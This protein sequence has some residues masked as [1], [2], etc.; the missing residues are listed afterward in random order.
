[1]TDSAATPSPMPA[2]PMP[3]ARRHAPAI[4]YIDNA[5]E[6]VA[7]P[8][9]A[10]FRIGDFTWL[11]PADGSAKLFALFG[12]ASLALP[13]AKKWDSIGAGF[14]AALEAR[15]AKV[16]PT[17]WGDERVARPKPDPEAKKRAALD[18]LVDVIRVCKHT[19]GL[20]FDEP[21]VR[22]KLADAAFARKVRKEPHI[23][24][25]IARRSGAAAQPP[26]TL[27]GL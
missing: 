6:P 4:V 23:A 12:A 17:A 15:F 1:M 9:A 27:A 26:D 11:M 14:G 21:T 10:G 24:A 13:I 5:G 25:E 18:E 19:A 3:A 22:G 20:A 16:S 7:M 2:S 8:D